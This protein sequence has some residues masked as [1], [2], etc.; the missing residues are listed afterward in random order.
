M[1]LVVEERLALARCVLVGSGGCSVEEKGG[2]EERSPSGKKRLKCI[3][4]TTKTT[5]LDR[6]V[7]LGP[8]HVA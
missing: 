8:D 6:P 1:L 7:A 4:L 2:E 3:H 5:H